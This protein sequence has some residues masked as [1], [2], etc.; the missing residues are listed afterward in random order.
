M[1]AP[2]VRELIESIVQSVCDGDDPRIRNPL[3]RLAT[4]ADTAALL[5]LRQRLY[6]SM[7]AHPPH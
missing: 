1:I 3:A 5:H 2:Q 6:D 4:V 7:P